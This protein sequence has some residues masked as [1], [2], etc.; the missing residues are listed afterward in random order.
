VPRQFLDHPNRA[1]EWDNFESLSVKKLGDN[2]FHAE[3]N[4]VDRQGK[5]SKHVFEGA[6]EEI[7]AGVE[8][9]KDLRAAERAHVLRSL[10]LR[11][12]YDD[13]PFPHIWFEPGIGWLFEQPGGPLH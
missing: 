6:R 4:L 10:N 5:A 2:K 11:T 12:I 3:L 13:S 9:N 8:A 7:R 1:G